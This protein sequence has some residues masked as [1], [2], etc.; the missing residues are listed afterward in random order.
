M[1]FDV[2]SPA[3]GGQRR[4]AKADGAGRRASRDY[5]PPIRPAEGRRALRALLAHPRGGPPRRY[6]HGKSLN[7]ARS[8]KP[9]EDEHAG[10][11]AASRCRRAATLAARSTRTGPSSTG[12][13]ASPCTM[14]ASAAGSGRRTRKGG[15]RSSSTPAWASCR[16]GRTACARRRL[17]HYRQAGQRAP[18][19]EPRRRAGARGAQ[20]RRPGF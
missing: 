9:D 15:I 17:A 12:C 14:G 1:R 3:T 11:C 6:P 5:G 10:S 2:A 7:K 4:A 8:G 16:G 18:A 13:R 20:R 19:D